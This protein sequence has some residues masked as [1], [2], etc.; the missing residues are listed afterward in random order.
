MPLIA[1]RLL[2]EAAQSSQAVEYLRTSGAQYMLPTA[3]GADH[4]L[5]GAARQCSLQRQR[6]DCAAMPDHIHGHRQHNWQQYGVFC[7]VLMGKLLAV[8]LSIAGCAAGANAG[9]HRGTVDAADL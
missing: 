6:F 7:F 3:R 1:G 8:P 9:A 5:P 4:Y 2:L